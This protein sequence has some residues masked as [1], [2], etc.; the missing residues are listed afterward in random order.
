MQGIILKIALGHVT[1]CDKH[2]HLQIPV[3]TQKCPFLSTKIYWYLYLSFVKLN[4]FVF[5]L[6]TFSP[7]KIY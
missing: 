3:C 6:A 4:I 1:V 5:V 2:W 7:Q